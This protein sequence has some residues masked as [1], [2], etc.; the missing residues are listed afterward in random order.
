MLQSD[1]EQA[2]G[3]A[4]ELVRC[5]AKG[6]YA[7]QFAARAWACLQADRTIMLPNFGGWFRWVVNP[8]CRQRN[9]M[10][11]QGVPKSMTPNQVVRDLLS[12][13]GEH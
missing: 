1:L 13:D 12:T 11:L 8:V 4:M 2:H 5:T 9:S 6:E 10:V 3:P 7:V